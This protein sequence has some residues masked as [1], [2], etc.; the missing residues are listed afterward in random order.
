[1]QDPSNNAHP[2][3][4]AQMLAPTEVLLKGFEFE[5]RSDVGPASSPAPVHQLRPDAT[6][7]LQLREG[8]RIGDLSLMIRY[9]NGSE[10]LEMPPIFRLPNAP[11]WFSG[12]ANLH[13]TLVPV[14][15]LARYLGVEHLPGE[16]PMLL[17]LEHGLD[18]AGV[19]IDGMPSRLRFDAADHSDDA[20]IPQALEGC[21]SQTYWANEKTWMDLQV[22]GLLSK[23][24]DELAAAGQ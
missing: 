9:E 8:F 22:N 10:L 24:N 15:D 5:L 18:A 14:F 7:G 16:K 4:S 19:V 12:I 1:M 13:G 11:P 20:P 17:V 2:L 3:V 21:V 23:L 6:H